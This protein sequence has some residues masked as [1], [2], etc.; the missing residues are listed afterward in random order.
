MPMMLSFLCS[1]DP[2]NFRNIKRILWLFELMSGLKVNFSK[3]KLHGINISAVA[4]SEYAGRLGCEVEK[5][6]L[7]YLGMKTGI[8]SRCCENWSWLTQRL[9]NRIAKRDG[10]NISLGG[11]ATLV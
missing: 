4:L 5:G 6:T 8:N 7:S 9:K 10:R 3:C 11:R 1:N 2:D